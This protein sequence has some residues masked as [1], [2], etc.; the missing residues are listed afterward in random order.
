MKIKQKR[1]LLFE[2][3][4]PYLHSFCFFKKSAVSTTTRLDSELTTNSQCSKADTVQN[5][6]TN[7]PI[8][9]PN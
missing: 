3:E 1:K 7:L 8:C 6:Q 2:L 5:W 9:D 4:A